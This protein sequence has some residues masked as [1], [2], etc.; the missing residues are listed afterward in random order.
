MEVLENKLSTCCD[1]PIS[2]AGEFCTECWEHTGGY[3]QVQ[4]NYINDSAIIPVGIKING[5]CAHMETEI[6]EETVSYYDYNR[7]QLDTRTD[8]YMVCKYCG[9]SIYLDD[10]EDDEYYED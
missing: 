3:M 1:A 9:D 10:D 8:E 4:I 5:N 6:E 2:E 7:G